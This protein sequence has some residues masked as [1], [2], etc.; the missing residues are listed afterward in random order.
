V[1][2]DGDPQTSVWR[3]WRVRGKTDELVP[4][5]EGFE[6]PAEVYRAPEMSGRAGPCHRAR[7][8]EDRHG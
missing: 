2:N 5:H 1:R 4:Q 8:Y 7:K 3:W 6:Q